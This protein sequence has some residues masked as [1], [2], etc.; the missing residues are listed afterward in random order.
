M[1]G[2][3]VLVVEDEP[4]IAEDIRETLDNIDFEVSGVAYD[5]DIALQE[6]AENTP[7]IVLLDVNLGSAMD[8]IEIADLINKKYQIPFIYLTSYAD[9]ST[10]DRA[11]HT[12][13]M[14]YIVKPFDDRDLFTTLEIALH[15]FSESQPKIELDLELLNSKVLAKITQK[16]FEILIS[17]FEGKT[18]RQMA[19]QH[20]ISLNTIKTH[21]KNLYDKLDVHTRT[22]AIAKLREMSSYHA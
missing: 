12:R 9:R 4:L 13:P 16:E 14:G 2:I 3:R 1:S 8:G 11:K 6:L 17:I 7:D 5:S 18:N 20:F 19:D 22:Q 10:V 21:V 15:N